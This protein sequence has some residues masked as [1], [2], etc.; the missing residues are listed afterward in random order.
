MATGDK[1]YDIA[2]ETT[3][4]EILNA[5]SNGAS[6]I[7]RIQSGFIPSGTTT[8]PVSKKIYGDAQYSYAVDVLI[9]AV[10]TAKCVVLVNNYTPDYGSFLAE[11][12]DS[13]TLRIHTAGTASNSSGGVTTRAITW[14]IIEFN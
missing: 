6:A 2:K 11:L 4:Q 12:V 1:N 10:N 14:Q 7:K 5:V 9:T 3:S 13:T 8:K